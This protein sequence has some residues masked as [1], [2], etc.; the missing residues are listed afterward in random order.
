VWTSEKR[1]K[2]DQIEFVNEGFER[3]E[4]V[5]IAEDREEEEEEGG[6]RE[7]GRREWVWAARSSGQAA[8][9]FRSCNC[10]RL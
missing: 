1:A 4:T 7:G 10:R 5:E 6:R 9:N 3:A 2:V 8:I